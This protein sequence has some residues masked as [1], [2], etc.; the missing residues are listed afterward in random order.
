VNCKAE[1][2]VLDDNIIRNTGS[3]KQVAA[4]LLTGNS[5]PVELKNNTISGHHETE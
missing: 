5:L 2:V 4:L 1:G 3:G